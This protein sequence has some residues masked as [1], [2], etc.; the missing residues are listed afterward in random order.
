M[1]NFFI[2]GKYKKEKVVIMEVEKKLLGIEKKG[3]RGFK[4]K[5]IDRRIMIIS[6][7]K[8]EGGGFSLVV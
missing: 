4:D 8:R 1:G 5:N 2:F 6:F 3:E 7:F